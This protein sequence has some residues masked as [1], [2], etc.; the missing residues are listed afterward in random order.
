MTNYSV[1][2][3]GRRQI[4]SS[5]FIIGALQVYATP[6]PLFSVYRLCQQLQHVRH[7]FSMYTTPNALVVAGEQ[8]LSM[9]I[10]ANSVFFFLCSGRRGV[11]ML[12]T[13]SS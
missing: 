9:V 10:S 11:L 2:Y 12:A 3:Y 7:W 6:P 1:S 8:G 4:R 13:M 5:E